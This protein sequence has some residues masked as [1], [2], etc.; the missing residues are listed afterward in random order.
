MRILAA[1]VLLTATLAG[2][3]ARAG[4]PRLAPLKRADAVSTHGPYASGACDACHEHGR[5]PHPGK[6]L[7]ASNDLCF[8]CHDEFRDAAPVRMDRRLHPV[9]Q[10]ACITCHSP[11]NSRKRKL[12]L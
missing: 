10:E 5:A 8:D 7:K 3:P 6:P 11:H 1:T 2:S 4:D 9:T 12:L